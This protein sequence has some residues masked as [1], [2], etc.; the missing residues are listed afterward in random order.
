MFKEL[1]ETSLNDI[2]RMMQYCIGN[3]DENIEIIRKKQK[4]NAGAEK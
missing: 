2:R 1:K 4:G 3:V